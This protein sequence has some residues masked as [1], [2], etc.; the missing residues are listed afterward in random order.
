MKEH[1]EDNCLSCGL[2]DAFGSKHCEGYKLIHTYQNI[3]HP[4]NNVLEY[5]SEKVMVRTDWAAN[6]M[7]HQIIMQLYMQLSVWQ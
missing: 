6:A 4:F 3:G 7:Y 5:G 2:I 1:F